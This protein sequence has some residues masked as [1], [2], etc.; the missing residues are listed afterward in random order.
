MPMLNGC[1]FSLS[2]VT[3]ALRCTMVMAYELYVISSYRL[4][5]CVDYAFFL[6]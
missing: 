6:N 4:R 1:N 3:A 2:M 5:F